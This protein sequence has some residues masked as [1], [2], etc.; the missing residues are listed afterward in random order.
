MFQPNFKHREESW[1][2]TV[3]QR[4]VFLTGTSSCLEIWWNNVDHQFLILRNYRSSQSKQKL[5]RKLRNKII[6]FYANKY[7][8]S[9]P[10]SRLRFPSL[11]LDELLFLQEHATYLIINR[12][13]KRQLHVCYITYDIHGGKF[14]LQARQL[15][16]SNFLRLLFRMFASGY[17]TYR[18][19]NEFLKMPV[20][21]GH[22][23]M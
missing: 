11:E 16:L 3:A 4:K 8:V 19:I 1:Q 5:K 9:K 21:R 12:K 17:C 22:L 6:T 7:P 2:Y 14:K 18:R 10:Q 13:K 20:D 23:Y 15:F